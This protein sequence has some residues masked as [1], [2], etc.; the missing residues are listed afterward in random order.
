MQVPRSARQF[1]SHPLLFCCDT[2]LLGRHDPNQF[3][4]QGYIV[5][6]LVEIQGLMLRLLLKTLSGSYLRLT[7]RSLS[8]CAPNEDLTASSPSSQR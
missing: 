7:E 3:G 6:C 1:N 8:K 4:A 5:A 2:S